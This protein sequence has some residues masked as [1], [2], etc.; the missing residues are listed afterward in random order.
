MEKLKT[1]TLS[2]GWPKDT[3]RLVLVCALVG[4]FMGACVLAFVD[5]I[6]RQKTKTFSSMDATK[7]SIPSVTFC[8]S[9]DPVEGEIVHD[10]WRTYVQPNIFSVIEGQVIEFDHEVENDSLQ[11]VGTDNVPLPDMT[12]VGE[13][14]M[15]KSW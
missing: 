2:L 12:S 7:L 6:N 11:A 1:T 8:I 4:L 13:K 5:L 3:L 14:T 15:K 10:F 9:G